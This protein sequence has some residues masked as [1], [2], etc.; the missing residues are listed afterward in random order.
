[1]KTVC[2]RFDSSTKLSGQ[3][4]FISSSLVTVLPAFCTNKSRT[5]KA[6]GVSG[7]VVPPLL[8]TRLCASR[9]NSSN[10]YKLLVRLDIALFLE[11]LRTFDRR[12]RTRE[13]H[14]Q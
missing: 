7:T 13:G 9:W 8:N 12:F 5:S 4:A 6:F 3:T 14:A 2:V 10:S 11:V 1:M